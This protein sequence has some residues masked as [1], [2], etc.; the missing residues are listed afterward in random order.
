MLIRNGNTWTFKREQALEQV[1]ADHLDALLSLTLL[2]RQ[3][4]CRG[5]ICDLVAVDQAQQLVIIEL[6]NVE[7]RYI[8][9][10]LTRYYDSLMAE[11]PWA[12]QIDYTQPARLI[13]VAPSFHR[14]NEVD[15]KYNHLCLEF[16]TFH[17]VQQKEQFWLH[18][19]S[20]D[21]EQGTAIPLSY[22]EVTAPQMD[23]LPKPPQRLLDALGAMPLETQQR[24][25]DLR[26]RILGFDARIQEIETPRS[27]GYGRGEKNWCVEL[28]FDRKQPSPILFLW[29]PLWN[30]RKRTAIGRYRLWT[31]WDN[32]LF[33][34][35]IPEGLGKAKPEEEWRQIP[36]EQWPRQNIW[37]G[38]TR[39]VAD[40]FHGTLATRIGCQEPTT[41]LIAVVD[42]ALQHWQAK[43]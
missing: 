39:L 10:Q 35:H 22:T 40:V 7:D 1:V 5:D 9:Q 25:L 38:K 37:G 20:V 41:S 13:A 16:F 21:T 8:V 24:I 3:Y 32:V 42:V 11:K 4:L 17:V 43:L 12:T 31:D 28:Y 30:N 34:A 6:K 18:L 14:H 19:R 26:A 29:L 27:I 15:R 36:K 23:D 2:Q 33:G